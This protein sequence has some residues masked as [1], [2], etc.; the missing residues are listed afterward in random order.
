MKKSFKLLNH[1][2]KDFWKVFH[3]NKIL[4]ITDFCVGSNSI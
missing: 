1:N 3:A 2:M 4:F